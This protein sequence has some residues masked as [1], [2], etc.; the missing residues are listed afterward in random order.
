MRSL[1]KEIKGKLAGFEPVAMI[2]L[3]PS[4]V[5]SEPSFFVIFTC[6]ASTKDPIPSKTSILFLSIR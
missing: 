6:V 2:I 1:S 4:I 5:S 3:V